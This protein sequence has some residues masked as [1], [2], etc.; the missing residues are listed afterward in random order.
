MLRFLIKD[1]RPLMK[2]VGGGS[3]LGGRGN[4][5]PLYKER[6]MKMEI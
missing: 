5:Y 1:V 2:A 4:V 3:V 6:V